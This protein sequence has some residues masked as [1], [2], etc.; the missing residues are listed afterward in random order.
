MSKSDTT[1]CQHTRTRVVDSR[2]KSDN[3]TRR[4]RECL[5]CLHRWTT[6]EMPIEEASRFR[7]IVSSSERLAKLSARIHQIVMETF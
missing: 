4:R 3:C 5:D 7:K 6:I 1:E 2:G